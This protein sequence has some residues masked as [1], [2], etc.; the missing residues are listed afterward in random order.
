MH[1]IGEFSL[2][3]RI[4]IKTLRYYHEEKLLVPDYIDEDS[5]YRYYRAQSVEK[6]AI[7]TF[8]REMEFS[9]AE[10]REIL[11]GYSDD[12]EV[13]EFLS[14]QKS[15]I[16]GKLAKY[17][18]MSGSLDAIIETIQRSEEMKKNLK[19][20]VEEKVVEDILFVGFRF[21][22][23]YNEVGKGFSKAARAAGR[24]IA[25]GALCLYY[26]GEYREKDADIEAGFPVSEQ[27]KGD[28]LSCRVIP[29][30]KAVTLVHKGSYDTLG[31]SYERVFE[32]INEHKLKPVTPTRE[33]Y[34]KG[35]GMIFRGNPEKYL[36]EIQIFVK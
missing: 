25:G 29:G 10:I 12:S 30:G 36:T 7:I 8:L 1:P 17:R 34:I 3:T 26:D 21:K 20:S 13:I 19:Y 31:H 9:I 4:S 28:D 14:R 18:S 16:E 2:I 23:K 32:Y 33:V 5:G 27:V 15:R 6:A 22:G 24:H 35:P 11:T